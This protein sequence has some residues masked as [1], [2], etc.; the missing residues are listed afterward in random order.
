MSSPYKRKAELTQSALFSNHYYSEL[1]TVLKICKF[2]F[3]LPNSPISNGQSFCIELK[4]HFKFSSAIWQKHT[5][6]FSTV[7]SALYSSKYQL[8][9]PYTFLF[10][11]EPNSLIQVPRPDTA[12]DGL[13]GLAVRPEDGGDFAP[14]VVIQVDTI[15]VLDRSQNRVS[16]LSFLTFLP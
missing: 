15:Q 14:V 2:I 6:K 1:Y 16:L 11:R 4:L 8:C 7:I 5:L 9:R 12:C 3:P 10:V 13:V